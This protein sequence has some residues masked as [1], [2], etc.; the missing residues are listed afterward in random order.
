MQEKIIMAKD[1][2]KLHF[3]VYEN[4]NATEVIQII[5]G[6]QERK[7][8]YREI[9][10]ILFEQGYTVIVS[11]TR[12]HGMDTDKLSFF[13]EKDGYKYLL[14]DQKLITKY[15]METYNVDKV[16]LLAHSLGT[17][18]ARNLFQTES[19]KY[20]KVIFTGY[21][22]PQ[23]LVNLGLFLTAILKKIKGPKYI[24]NFINSKSEGMFSKKIKNAKTPKDWVST[25]ED[26]IDRYLLDKYCSVPFCVSAYNDAFH[27]IKNMTQKKRYNNVNTFLPILLL[28][29]EDD[30]CVGGE[31]GSKNSIKVLNKCGFKNIKKITYKNMRHELINDEGNFKVY[32]DIVDFLKD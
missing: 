13:K 17:V 21:L 3:D 23:K 24:S 20:S 15:I 7:E 6:M 29:G 4:P 22:C 26:K 16:I 2:Y 8:R 18:I 32:E 11:N 9:S 14:Y 25:N 30:L 28:G 1:G 27:L 5:H 31:K 10:E 19:Y 12:G